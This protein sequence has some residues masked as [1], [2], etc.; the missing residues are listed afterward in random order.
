MKLVVVHRAGKSRSERTFEVSG[1]KELR[2]LRRAHKSGQHPANVKC[3][4]TVV[5]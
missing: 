3:A 5:R 4:T 2:K 1:P